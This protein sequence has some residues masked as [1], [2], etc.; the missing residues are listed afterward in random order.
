VKLTITIAFCMLIL[1]ACN[2]PLGQREQLAADLTTASDSIIDVGAS[3]APLPGPIKEPLK[4]TAKEVVEWI[5]Y[6]LLGVG[7]AGYG[8]KKMKDS[9]KGKIV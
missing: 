8:V 6:S 1:M 9:P 4:N 2:L 3:V 5:I 7:V